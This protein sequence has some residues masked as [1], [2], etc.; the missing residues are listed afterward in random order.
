MRSWRSSTPRRNQVGLG[1]ENVGITIATESGLALVVS[2]GVY[3]GYV[4]RHFSDARNGSFLG[5]T[6]KT[7]ANEM[8]G[9]ALSSFLVLFGLL[10]GLLAIATFRRLDRIYDNKAHRED[11]AE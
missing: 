2:R 4:G 9:F 6:G 10:L 11:K 7:R 8:V 1:H 5:F 3:R